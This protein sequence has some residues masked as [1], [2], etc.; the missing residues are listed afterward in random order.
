M[1]HDV[2]ERVVGFDPNGH[3]RVFAPT[4]YECIEEAEAYARRRPDTSPTDQWRF[5]LQRFEGEVLMSEE[6]LT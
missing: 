2:Y 1:S 5:V 3:L 4:L 6:V